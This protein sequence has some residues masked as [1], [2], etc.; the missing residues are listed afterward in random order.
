MAS[1]DDEGE[2]TLHDVSEYHFVDGKDEPVSIAELPIV[3]GNDQASEGEVREIFLRGYTDNRRL[4]VYRQVKAWK[5][6]IS[7]PKPEI[8]VLSSKKEWIKLLQ[9]RKSYLEFIRT[10]IITVNFLHLLKI[11]P[12]ISSKALWEKLSKRFNFEEQP[13]ENDLVDH[14]SL[15]RE[16]VKRDETLK[17]S[18]VL[19]TF[20]ENP[21]KK[22]I[23]DEDVGTSKKSSF[24]VDDNSIDVTYMNEE[25][26]EESDDEEDD[27]FD[28]VCALCDNGGDI[29]CC[30][31]RCLRSFHAT[32]EAGHDSQC[33]SLGLSD[34][35]VKRLPVFL[36][37]NCQYNQHQCY[38]CGKLGSSDKSSKAE[39][40]RCVIAT[41]GHFYHPQC[42]SKLL[43]PR[44]DS[45]AKDLSEKISAGEQF[46][47]PIHECYVCKEAENKNESD[48]QFAV[49]RRCPKSYHRKCLPREI[50]FDGD[51]DE[52]LIA[53][54]WEGLL[55]N[56]RILIYCLDHEIDEDLCTPLRNHIKFP[57]LDLKKK[58]VSL[59]SSGGRTPL[60]SEDASKKNRLVKKP[61]LVEKSSTFE[62]LVDSSKRTERGLVGQRS[63]GQRKGVD[64][65]M[66]T[67][68]KSSSTKFRKPLGSEEGPSLGD[69]LYN[70]ISP[71]LDSDD[72]AHT[73]ELG[74]NQLDGLVME[75]SDSSMDLDA[76]A[77]ERILSI[78][79]DTASNV[80]IEEIEKN[81]KI[82]G[83]CVY[84]SKS[85]DKSI[86]RGRV[87]ACIE[88]INAAQQKIDAG[89][90]VENA[91]SICDPRL[92]NQIV[93]WKEK[94]KV[95]LA[96]FLYGMRYTSY[97]RH[98]T[99][100]DKL[101]AIVDRLH[102]YV[103]DGDTI[104]DFCCGSNDFS[105]ILKQKLD[106]MDKRKCAFKNF[107]IYPPKNDFSFEKRDWMTVSPKD[108]PSG[109]NLIMGLNPPFGVNAHLANKFISKALQFKPK[110]LILIVPRET[111]RL[112]GQHRNLPYDL[113]W[114]DGELLSG[115][116]FYLPGSI[117]VNGKQ[118]EDWNLSA[119]PLYLWSHPDWTSTHKSIAAQKGHVKA[120]KSEFNENHKEMMELNP[121]AEFLGKSSMPVDD[122][123]L[124]NEPEQLVEQRASGT[125]KGNSSGTEDVQMYG[126]NQSLMHSRDIE[127]ENKSEEKLLNESSSGKRSDAQHS[128]SSSKRL[129]ASSNKELSRENPS[130][131]EHSS[132]S[133]SRTQRQASYG[134]EKEV[135]RR[136]KSKDTE[137][138]VQRFNG[139]KKNK[140]KRKGYMR[141]EDPTTGGGSRGR[142]P[143]GSLNNED[144][145]LGGNDWPRTSSP[146]IRSQNDHHFMGQHRESTDIMGY[147]PYPRLSEPY[148]SEQVPYYGPPDPGY[149]HP[150]MSH[151]LGGSRP[152]FA[153][154]Y[155]QLAPPAPS[156]SQL[157]PPVN[158][159]Q[160]YTSTM[161]RYAPR[162]DELNH[163]RMNE[164]HMDRSSM[165]DPR[166]GHPA[167]QPPDSFGFAPNPYSSFPTH[168]SS[169]WLYE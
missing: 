136:T 105:L 158:F 76:E 114:E 167:S 65:A 63:T 100:V 155:S 97:G 117:D 115:K 124:L 106:E 55:P 101:K 21:R 164:P 130:N 85:M 53:R 39:V 9:A 50:A 45:K 64:T 162:L 69:R 34:E 54:A 116:S 60:V 10:I 1:S 22:R 80:T 141:N 110:I 125:G 120:E 43:S 7:L 26:Q 104:V 135:D 78:I 89:G 88:A 144:A 13:C 102:W 123:S 94:L 8:S 149:A 86:T 96:P 28:Y 153:P 23:L 68:K 30:E 48:L 5:F 33:D 90:S 95:Y 98:F 29:L 47:C 83:R 122:Q 151:H 147:Q 133:G 148:R 146:G 73:S 17:N 150:R 56:G 137:G 77:K 91:K 61:K 145:T 25:N 138:P 57:F 163:T 160:N 3:W 41:C 129:K 111:E 118:M 59:I 4:S 112:D 159:P 109:S 113:V 126:S 127:Q 79:E 72:L 87:E 49:C 52:E 38:A 71:N 27:G 11:K 62:K 70:L 131:Q 40:F 15:I 46:S 74:Q 24:I 154:S 165:Y 31:G 152:V 99:S 142:N 103:Q 32:T 119:P 81:C 157:A 121:S 107:D 42:V 82:P 35:K 134:S 143:R 169:G 93:R 66:K 37:N 108:L 92:L 12:D 18:N 140:K 2:E 67:L 75:E 44:N 20:L 16:T 156:Y 132:V 128:D 168:G 84:S 14:I 166:R 36:C 19:I 139:K 51:E 6:D 161:Q 58:R